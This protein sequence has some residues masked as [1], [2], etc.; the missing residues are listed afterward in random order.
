M[1]S[2]HMNSLRILFSYVPATSPVTPALSDGSVQLL[3]NESLSPGG[4]ASMDYLHTG[5]IF[6][7]G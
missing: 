6:P 4:P 7:D 2:R 3:G 1:C 5:D